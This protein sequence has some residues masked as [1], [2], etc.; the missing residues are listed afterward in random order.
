MGSRGRKTDADKAMLAKQAQDVNG[1]DLP[2]AP[3]WMSEAAQTEWDDIVATYPA[4]RFPRATW[5]MLEAYCTHAVNVRKIS[6][7]INEADESDFSG[8]GKLLSWLNRETKTLASFGVRLGIARTSLP[9]RHNHDPET[10][11]SGQPAPWE[12][13]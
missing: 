1:L 8:Y 2:P 11:R 6:K 4:D 13:T 10:T 9:G 7:M 12:D 5:P 3:D